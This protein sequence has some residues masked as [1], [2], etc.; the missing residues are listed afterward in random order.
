M[1]YYDF[2]INLAT[3]SWANHASLKY[4]LATANTSL[5]HSSDVVT[6]LAIMQHDNVEIIVILI[7]N[8]VIKHTSVARDL[9]Y[10]IHEYMYIDEYV[11][12]LS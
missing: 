3:T 11:Q 5:F 10:P 8:F 9:S 1:K 4:V 6:S 2:V 7:G 12:L